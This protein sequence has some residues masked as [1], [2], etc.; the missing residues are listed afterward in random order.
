G[1]FWIVAE[2]PDLTAAWGGAIADQLGVAM[3]PLA[4]RAALTVRQVSRASAAVLVILDNVEVWSGQQAPAPLPQGAHVRMLVTTRQRHLGGSRFV[5]LRLGFLE[6]EY[7]RQL[8]VGAA[9]RPG[10]D[11]PGL[12]DLLAHLAGHALAIELAGV[13]LHEFP[14]Y[15]PADYLRRLRRGE[16]P[17]EAVSDLVRYEATAWQAFLAIWESLE[18]PVQLA[19][20][21]A[22]CF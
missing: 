9:G 10:E 11:L 19:W 21:V 16:R 8:L 4:E 22:A 13:Y 14:D 3:M 20:Q 2:N 17:G 15:T 5:H 18:G 1:I 7:A 12:E 6:L